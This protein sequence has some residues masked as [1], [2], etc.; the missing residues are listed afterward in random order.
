MRYGFTAA[1][2]AID[3][4]EA[5]G[6][7]ERLG[8]E[9]A[10]PM[11][12]L[13]QL[14]RSA[15]Y[16]AQYARVLER[17][18]DLFMLDFYNKLSARLQRYYSSKDRPKVLRQGND[19]LDDLDDLDDEA[20]GLPKPRLRAEPTAQRGYEAI[21]RKT[22][23][24]EEVRQGIK[25]AYAANAEMARSAGPA[26]MQAPPVAATQAETAPEVFVPE[27]ATPETEPKRPAGEGMAAEGEIGDG[28]VDEMFNDR[29]LARP[30]VEWY[31]AMHEWFES[32]GQGPPP[33][34]PPN[35]REAARKN[36]K[37]NPQTNLLL[38]FEEQGWKDM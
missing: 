14:E 25:D 11:G 10:F 19:T 5:E 27:P 3:A 6:R 12:V 2:L 18:G 37:G 30:L 13:N 17:Q 21:A 29:T 1:G 7:R 4:L 32:T 35:I 16:F 26:V 24:Y 20:D 15:Q 8:M 28:H 22:G 9:S 34:P 23:Q 36:R 33:K 31:R 38:D